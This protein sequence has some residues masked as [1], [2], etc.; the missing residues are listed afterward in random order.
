MNTKFFLFLVSFLAFAD[1]IS[2]SEPIL[3]SSVPKEITIYKSGAQVLRNASVTVPAGRSEIVFKALSPQI[4]E[5][6]IQIKGG[7]ALTIMSVSFRINYLEEL[8]KQQ[9]IKQL[10]TQ[11]NTLTDRIARL[12]NDVN[13]YKQEENLLNRNQVQVIGVQNN[14]LKTQD[15]KELADFQRTRLTEMLGKQYDLDQQIKQLEKESGEIRHQLDALNAQRNNPSGEI[16]VIVNAAKGAVGNFCLSYFIDQAGWEPSYDMRVKD[17]NSPISLDQKANL[18]QQSGETWKDVKLRLSTGNPTEDNDLPT[19]NPWLLRFASPRAHA[20]T[21]HLG[22]RFQVVG[23]GRYG[24]VSGQVLDERG[25]PITG[26]AIT[27]K[28]TTQGTRA[29]INGNF[30]LKLSGNAVLVVSF[31]GYP[32]FELP[33][34][35]N[36]QVVQIYLQDNSAML[37]EVVVAYGFSAK[38]RSAEKQDNDDE[39]EPPVTVLQLPTTYLY[40]ID[41][42]VTIESDGKIQTVEIKNYEL[43]AGYRYYCAPKIEAAAFLS[44]QV[45]GWESLGL[46]SGEANLFFEGTFLGKSYLEFANTNDTLELSLGRD[47]NISVSRTKLKD[48]TR[49][50]FMSGK[51]EDSR[52]FEIAVKNKKTQAI[53][54]VLEDQI[55]VSTN[56][57]VTIEQGEISGA[58]LNS[59]T[60]KLR[61]TLSLKPAEDKKL[62]F[63]YTVRYPKEKIVV[64]E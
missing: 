32:N 57:N 1:F 8:S 10:E 46:L 28:G 55:P 23:Y 7:D 61:W 38:R 56:K 41:L 34:N 64:L 26:A 39:G 58:A 62:R 51:K 42:P 60:G 49:R 63:G 18:F 14:P 13:V 4:K 47:R 40:E 45:T 20:Q 36:G 53:T 16:T 33:T 15:L 22:G 24:E 35:I 54:L 17:V 43:P 44:A 9:E 27:I 50:Q 25:E 6:T 5:N 12:R 21:Q 37:G 31:I 30:T 29:D 2:A 52:S 48:F 11:L 19:L 59:E 3:A